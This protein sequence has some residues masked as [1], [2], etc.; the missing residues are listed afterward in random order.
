MENVM[1][2]IENLNLMSQRV[3]EGINTQLGD[4]MDPDIRFDIMVLMGKDNTVRVMWNLM[5]SLNQAV[6]VERLI[7]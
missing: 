5:D 4:I 2:A 6:G 3:A 1:L 7:P